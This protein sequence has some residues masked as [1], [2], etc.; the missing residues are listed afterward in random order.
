MFLLAIL[1]LCR[2]GHT[3]LLAIALTSKESTADYEWQYECW[4]EAVGTPP[5]MMFTDA[6]P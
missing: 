2:H 4:L 6:D 5:Q 3:V 1:C